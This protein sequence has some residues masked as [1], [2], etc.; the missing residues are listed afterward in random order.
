MAE[1]VDRCINA[2]VRIHTYLTTPHT[3]K[4]FSTVTGVKKKKNKKKPKQIMEPGQLE[5]SLGRKEV[6]KMSD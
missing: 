1:V 4:Q 3:H 6:V 5:I 2:L